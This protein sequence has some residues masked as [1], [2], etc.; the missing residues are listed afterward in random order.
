MAKHMAEMEED[1]KLIAL[2]GKKLQWK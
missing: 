2:Y 1:P